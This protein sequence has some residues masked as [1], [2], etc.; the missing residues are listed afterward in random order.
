MRIFLCML[1]TLMILP[2]NST[3]QTNPSVTPEFEEQH[4]RA[5]DLAHNDEHDKSLAILRELLKSNPTYYP[6]LR[7]YV[8]V[9]SWNNMCDESLKYYKKIEKYPDQESYL[10]IP[11][12]ECMAAAG[13]LQ[14][15]KKILANGLSKSPDDKDLKETL[16][17]IQEQIDEQK[18]ATLIVNLRN[19]NTN[20]PN[21]EWRFETRY[22]QPLTEGFSLYGKY[23]FGTSKDSVIDTDDMSRI[24][25]GALIDLHRTLTLDQEFSV[26]LRESEENGSRTNLNFAPDNLWDMNLAYTTYWEGISLR[27]KAQGI[28]AKGWNYNVGFHT[29]DYR[30]E[31][32]AS[33][34][35]H[36][37]TDGNQRSSFYT[38]GGYAFEL[39]PKRE[40][41]V[42]L[43]LD[44]TRNSIIPTAFYFNP[45]RSSTV[46]LSYK[47]DLVF[48]SK[49]LRHVD[50]LIVTV[51]SSDQIGFGSDVIGGFF[52]QQDY[53]FNKTASLSYGLGYSTKVYDGNREGNFDGRLNFNKRF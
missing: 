4:S 25:V 33:I 19:N 16:N 14:Q 43:E 1:V 5:I 18:R 31:W 37:F 13:K 46:A 10:I 28:T 17:E 15:A 32:L 26:D 6:V 34:S 3:A 44:L 11:V 42:V 47:L 45:E 36:D 23:F 53:D 51:G 35:G 52:Y 2:F 41:R 39:A 9:S 50:T 21:N 27:A 29:D 20:G 49:F 38:E 30:W 48:D 12:S 7:D 8:V 22:I 40:Q 24:G